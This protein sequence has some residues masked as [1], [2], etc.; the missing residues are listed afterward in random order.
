MLTARR[1][2][3]M[4]EANPAARAP[5]RPAVMSREEYDRALVELRRQH[6]EEDARL[7][8]ALRD[9]CAEIDR[10]NVR[11]AELQR[12]KAGAIPPVEPAPT[13]AEA[14]QA[15]APPAEPAPETAKPSSEGG[16]RQKR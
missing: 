9:A 7:E 2:R 14:K 5:A 12:G 3:A 8:Q 4:R 13:A 11:L 6:A 1:L 15:A 16:K 10:L